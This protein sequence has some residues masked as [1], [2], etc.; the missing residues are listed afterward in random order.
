MENRLGSRNQSHS[1]MSGFLLS[2]RTAAQTGAPLVIPPEQVW[3]LLSDEV[4]TEF[5]RMEAHSLRAVKL[6]ENYP[7]PPALAEARSLQRRVGAPEILCP[8]AETHDTPCVES[9]I[10]EWL[11][12]HVALLA[13]PDRYHYSVAHLKTFFNDERRAGRLGSKVM[14]KDLTPEV[15]SRFRE[16]RSASGVG[17]HT[18]SRDLAALRGALTW[19]WKHQR[20]LKPPPFISDVPFHARGQPRDRV[21]SQEEVAA[22]V[23]AC[24]GRPDREHVIRFIVIE[25][26]TAGRPQAVLELEHTNIDLDRNLID[27]KQPG[28]TYPRKRRAIVPMAKAV[29]PWVVGIEGK[30]IKYRV[31]LA[32]KEG[33]EAV[34]FERETKS[35]KTSWN[36]ACREAG[37]E[38]ATP[39]TL[40]HTMLTW[41][42]ERGV[43]YEQRQVLAGH[44]A[45]GTTARHYEHLS[46]SYLKT[47]IEEVDAYFVELRKLTSAIDGPAACPVR[48]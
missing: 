3:I 35:I 45:R 23:D 13:A 30:L 39:K 34:F 12:F 31:P 16:W 1:T 17:G 46:P 14:V 15:Q 7:A 21:L 11:T 41:L 18:V 4:Y 48:S 29:R 5:S 33:E 27:P 25:L 37:V 42:A 8:P 19:A 20:I 26:G 9:L 10:A 32:A 36:A 38:G 40:R 28:R 44:S 22:I 2:L 6:Y 43:P 47:A 24:A